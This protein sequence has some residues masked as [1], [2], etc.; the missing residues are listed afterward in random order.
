MIRLMQALLKD[1][2]RQMEAAAAADRLVQQ[3]PASPESSLNNNTYVTDGT[4]MNASG[5]VAL[6]K[7]LRRLAEAAESNKMMFLIMAAMPV[8]NSTSTINDG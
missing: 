1:R 4:S 7:L 5:R 2:R 6:V 8:G 3:L